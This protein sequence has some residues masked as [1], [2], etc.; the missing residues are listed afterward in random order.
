MITTN[1]VIPTQY[2]INSEFQLVS[3]IHYNYLSRTLEY[4][5]FMY[6][7][8]QLYADDYPPIIIYKYF[9][10]DVDDAGIEQ[11]ITDDLNTRFN[12]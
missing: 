5:Y 12:S 10:E 6:I 2:G 9:I 7:S 1:Y 8:Q 11:A 4:E 3:S